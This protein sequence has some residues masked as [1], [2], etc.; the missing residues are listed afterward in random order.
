VS[1]VLDRFYAA[2]KA[3]SAP[4]L[5]AC[6]TA[7][8]VLDWQGT[9]RI[10][11]AGTWRGVD[12]LLT[13][14]QRLDAHVEILNVQRLHELQDASVTVVVL[15]GHW[16][17]KASNREIRAIACNLFTFDSGKVR[18]YTVVNNTAAFAEGL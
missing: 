9:D 3:L 17:L 18:T 6:T 12:G 1:P 8:F 2:L 14:V 10:P 13:F 7:D 4:D 16:R 15:R 5:A 11:W